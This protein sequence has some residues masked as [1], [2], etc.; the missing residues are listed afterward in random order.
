L[1]PYKTLNSQ[2][3]LENKYVKIFKDKFES[4]NGKLGEY[5]YEVRGDGAF[6]I[7][8]DK[9]GN[10]ILVKEYKYPAKAF[11]INASAGSIDAGETPE[12]GARREVFEE[13][14]YQSKSE[15]VNLGEMFVAA[16][17]TP[18]NIHLFYLPDCEKIT[19]ET[20]GE[21]T[22]ETEVVLL[23]KTEAWDWIKSDKIK[24]PVTICA[25]MK[26]CFHLK[27]YPN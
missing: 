8:E 26:T 23:P 22:E 20:G 7:A 2:I 6:T 19:D 4:G 12:E 27:I 24:S 9:S 15:L 14:G 1:K 11:V 16:S 10:F 13:T 25:L 18:D 17:R 5:T 3:I 21:I